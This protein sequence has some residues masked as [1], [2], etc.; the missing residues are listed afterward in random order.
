MLNKI[1]YPVL[2]AKMKGMHAN[3][4]SKEE[5]EE[6]LSQTTL[7][8]AISFL[9]QKFPLLE[10]INEDMH[11]KEL[12]QELNNL[13]IIDIL[14]LIKYLNDS[15]KEIF[16]EFLAKYEINCVKNVFRNVVTNRDSKSNLKNID[17]WTEKM[18]HSIDGINDIKGIPEFFEL[19][20]S[21]SYY[22]VF[23]EYEN[24]TS[25]IPLEKLEVKLD[26]FYFTKIYKIAEKNNKELKN[27]IGTEIDLLNVIWIYRSKKYFSYLEEEIKNILIPINFKINNEK[28]NR[29]IVATDF[30]EMK[31]ILKETVY[32]NVFSS[33]EFIEHDKDKYL[34]NIY[35]KLFRT[36]LFNICTVFCN[37]NLIDIEI[38]NII[39]IIEGIRYKIDKTEIQKRLII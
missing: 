23:K 26:Q 36:K 29:L 2:N 13:F 30:E 34:Y 10:N 19:I 1:K 38:K 18:F 33:E 4:L 25:D 15:D 22:K 24:I 6:L 37:I 35:L 11:R 17:N 16:F 27:M 21:E 20:Q 39:N 9:K 3:H 31:M 8:D 7:R 12:E 32:K 14:K 28:I 5:L